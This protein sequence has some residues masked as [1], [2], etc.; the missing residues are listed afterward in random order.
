L[1][2]KPDSRRLEIALCGVGGQGALLAGKILAEAGAKVFPYVTFFPNYASLMRGWPSESITILSD[3]PIRSAVISKIK[4]VVLMHPTQMARYRS[5][6]ALGGVMVLDGSLQWSGAPG[7]DVEVLSIPA[8][9][10]AADMGDPRVA[11]LILL[12][13]SL[14][15]SGEVP[16]EAVE[17]VLEARMS[18]IRW[19]T[20]LPRNKNA[21]RKGM[22]LAAAE[23]G[24]AGGSGAGRT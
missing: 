3:E 16:F 19:E 13:A 23:R 22:E 17:K 9:R 4:T 7:D 8:S 5:R 2:A 21:I 15:V 11:N 10:C 12:G 18:G 24:R 6:V 20:L 14:S 1:S